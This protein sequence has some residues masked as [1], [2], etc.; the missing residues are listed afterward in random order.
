MTGLGQSPSVGLCMQDYKSV[1]A[2]VMICASL[3]DT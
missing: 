2:A 1:R 3:V